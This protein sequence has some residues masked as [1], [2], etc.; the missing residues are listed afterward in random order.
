[1]L[2]GGKIAGWEQRRNWIKDAYRD[3]KYFRRKGILYG[4][5]KQENGSL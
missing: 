5:P 3:I 2:R 1:L 4:N